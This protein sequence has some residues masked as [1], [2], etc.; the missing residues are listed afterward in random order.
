MKSIATKLF[1]AFFGLTLVVLVATLSLARWSFEQGFLDYIN[2]VEE[3]RLKALAGVLSDDYIEAGGQ[4]TQATR[5]EFDDLL[6][7]ADG[8][9]PTPSVDAKLPFPLPPDGPMPTPVGPVPRVQSGLPRVLG[10]P[11]HG[12]WPPTAL[13]DASGKQI[14]G[15]EIVSSVTVPTVVPVTVEGE[16]VGQILSAP[17]R[18]FDSPQ[19]TAFARQQLN[20]SLSIG[21]LSLAL[22][23]VVSWLLSRMLLAPVRRMMNSVSELSGGDYSIR[24]N[25]KR[26]DELGVLMNDIDRLAHTLEENR[27]S[28]QRWLADI[29]HELRTPVTV[30]TGEIESMKDGVRPLDKT[31]LLSLDQEVTRVRR[32]ID[33]LYQ[34]SV[35]DIGGL[36]YNFAETDVYDALETTLASVRPRAGE[37]GIELSLS[38]D[39]AALIRADARRLDQLFYNLL[40]N[41]LAYTDSPGRIEC[42]ILSEPQELLIR[43]EDTPPGLSDDAYA[44]VFD[45]LY[46][47]DES[48]SRRTEGAGLG[49]AICRNIVVAHQS[50]IAAL[51]STLGGLCIEMRFP[52]LLEEGK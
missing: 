11:M 15:D 27:S 3:N 47:Q 25:A 34:L 26:R 42:R 4:W 31:Q 51:P 28:R 39:R 45:P 35:S 29:S 20:S 48:R 17:N 13:Y 50:S 30:L 33:D 52:R 23:A 5:R 32:L 46:R 2:A 44:R 49:L 43:I 12:P 6:R 7:G 18:R 9:G 36:R 37:R 21:A 22:A 38:G 16:T 40:E 1:L 24:M 14:A 10:L 41:A 8:E 19:E